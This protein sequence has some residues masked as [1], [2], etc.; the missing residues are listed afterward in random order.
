MFQECE[1]SR[2]TTLE[3]D[4]V[5]MKL[6][7]DDLVSFIQEQSEWLR[8]QSALLASQTSRVQTMTV[9]GDS[10]RSRISELETRLVALGIEGVAMRSRIRSLE[11]SVT[12]IED[13]MEPS[14]TEF[15]VVVPRP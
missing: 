8:L 5:A 15:A 13:N 10:M 9:E 2:I 3:M 12:V 1:I 4:N 6:R 14:P 7:M 11:D